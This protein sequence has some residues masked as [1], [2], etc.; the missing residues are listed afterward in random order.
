MLQAFGRFVVSLI[1]RKK[2]KLYCP[3]FERIL[4]RMIKNPLLQ[5]FT[6]FFNLMLRFMYIIICQKIENIFVG[7]NLEI[8]KPRV[9]DVFRDLTDV[10]KNLC[11]E[12]MFVLK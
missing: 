11:F 9:M 7:L 8:V 3:V 4:A 1:L 6:M 2:N 5:R 12:L 10:R